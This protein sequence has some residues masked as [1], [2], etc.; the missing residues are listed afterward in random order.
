MNYQAMVWLNGEYVG[1]HEGGYLPFEFEVIRWLRG[2]D[3]ELLV[4]VLDATDDRQRY[5]ELPFSEVPH[6]KQSWYGPIGG[7]WQSAWLE[8]RPRLHIA[9]VQLNPSPAEATISVEVALSETPPETCQVSCVVT[10][11]EGQTVGFGRLDQSLGGVIRL[12]TPPAL[13]NADSRFFIR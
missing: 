2:G 12:D 3:N 11:P 4:R 6:G 9:Q 13:W 7:L 8:F 5:P 1:E 10:N